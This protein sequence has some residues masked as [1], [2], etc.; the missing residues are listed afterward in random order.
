MKKSIKKRIAST[1]MALILCLTFLPATVLAEES[2]TVSKLDFRSSENQPT[3]ETKYT[4]TDGGTAKWEPS[5]GSTPNKLT[6]NGV[7]MTDDYYVVAVPANTEIV[8]TGSNKITE[9]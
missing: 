6:L 4:I 5:D 7:T 3:V 9:N 2:K 1:A 8:L